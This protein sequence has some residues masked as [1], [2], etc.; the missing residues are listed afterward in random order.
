MVRFAE[1]IKNLEWKWREYAV[2]EIVALA[3]TDFEIIPND[4]RQTSDDKKNKV[5]RFTL[6]GSD[7]E[8]L[9]TLDG[10]DDTGNDAP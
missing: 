10:I 6:D 9:C 3:A 8:A 1:Y 7:H 4:K 5:Q 2:V